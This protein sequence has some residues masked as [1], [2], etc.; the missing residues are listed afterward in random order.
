[1]AS[2]RFWKGFAAGAAAGAG[3][4]LGSWFLSRAIFSK[5]FHVVRLEKSLQIG[6]PVDDVFR[7]WSDFEHL[8]R[9]VRLIEEVRVQGKRSHWKM[10]LNGRSFEWDAELT[11]S[12][13][14]QALGW[15][16]VSGP[17]HTGR[18]NFSSLGNDTEV[19]VVM[20]YAPVG[21]ELAG[22]LTGQTAGLEHCLAQALRDFKAA[23]EGKGQQT[24]EAAGTGRRMPAGVSAQEE[25]RSS[26]THGASELSGHTQT[27]RFG[28]VPNAT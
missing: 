16:S 19:H 6:R 1:M 11:Q 25:V 10:R 24:A 5:Q 26:G 18:I 3:A 14:N 9:L 7:A 22:D 21:G 2:R 20:N 27:S 23:L 15:K 17:K 4:G 13:P 12:I 8:P 28:G